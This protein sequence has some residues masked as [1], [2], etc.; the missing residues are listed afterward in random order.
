MKIYT[1]RLHGAKVKDFNTKEEAQAFMLDFA[2]MQQEHINQ[3][4]Y[5]DEA[6]LKSDMSESKETIKHIM[7]KK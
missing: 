2:M 3:L 4:D 1:V 6:V 7:E 5:L